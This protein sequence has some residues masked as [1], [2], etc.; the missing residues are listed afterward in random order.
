MAPFKVDETRIR[1]FENAERFY[2]WLAANHAVE[3]EIWIRLHKKNSGLSSISQN[4][5]IAPSR[6]MNALRYRSAK[7]A[8]HS[9]ALPSASKNLA[10]S[11]T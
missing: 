11:S 7:R 10:I 9:N 3:P 6:W 4:E 1:E 5:A 8:L 2:D